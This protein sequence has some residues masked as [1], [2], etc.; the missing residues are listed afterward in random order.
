MLQHRL[1]S[2]YTVSRPTPASGAHGRTMEVVRIS[3]PAALTDP[4][5][6]TAQDATD[7]IEPTQDLPARPSLRQLLIGALTAVSATTLLSLLGVWGTILGMGLSSVLTVVGNYMYSSFVQRT[8]KKLKQ[9]RSAT[10]HRRGKETVTTATHEYD[11]APRLDLG[12]KPD[13]EPGAAQ[14]ATARGGAEPMTGVEAATEPAGPGGRLK[15]AWR[16]MVQRYGRRRIVVS[17]VVVFALLGGT[18]TVV[19]LAAGRP[20]ADVV[21]NE[22]GTG[23]TLFH[24]PGTDGSTTDERGDVEDI[25]PGVGDDESG[26]QEDQDESD[27]QVPAE[28]PDPSV[29]QEQEPAEEQPGDEEQPPPEQPGDEPAEGQPAEETAP[30]E[31]P[32]TE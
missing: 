28:E 13:R 29:P 26:T 8:E 20:L 15:A 32:A 7:S 31:E 4:E 18:I 24:G 23:T 5:R 2:G 11:D 14:Q 25:S 1:P 27:E 17:I 19:E 6:D 16:S 30:V 9:T 12:P 21:R 3:Q 22:A 10:P